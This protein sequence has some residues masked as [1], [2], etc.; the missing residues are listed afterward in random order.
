MRKNLALGHSEGQQVG[1]WDLTSLAGAGAIKSTTEDMVK[2]LAANMGKSGKGIYQAMQLSHKQTTAEG[3]NPVVGL[4]WITMKIGEMEIIWHNG[5][6]GGYRSFAGFVKGGNKGVVVLSNSTGSVDDIGTNILN[7]NSPIQKIKK[8]IASELRSIIDEK[9][10]DA[11]VTAYKKLKKESQDE[12]DFGETELNSLGYSYM[13]NDQLDIAITLFELN[14]ESYPKAFNVYDS[15]GEAYMARGDNEQAIEN[16][17]KSVE[18]NPANDGGIAKLKELGISDIS[19]E[20]VISDEVLTSY[21]G[22][23]ELAPGF[24]LS[25]TKNGSQMSAQATG[26]PTFEIYPKTESKFYLKVVEAQLQFNK[27]D[28]GKVESVT[29]FQGGREIVGKKQ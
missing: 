14:I 3:G 4:G 20:V 28:E 7:A 11:G 25:I 13:G 5:G 2:Y 18:I 21:I 1:N 6:T 15:M 19:K 22:K 27:N 26:Q 24:I 16:Y 10:I 17:K 8:S 9:G 29:L 23:Y 12:Y